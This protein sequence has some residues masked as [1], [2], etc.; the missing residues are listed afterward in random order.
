M[1]EHTLA[2]CD[3]G[4]YVSARHEIVDLTYAIKRATRDTVLLDL[5]S[6]PVDPEDGSYPPHVMRKRVLETAISVTGES[7]IE[8][9]RRLVA[10]HDHVGCLNFASAKN[11]GGGFLDGARAQEESLA[12]S[13]ALYPCLLTQPAHYARNK[14]NHSALYLD[15]AIYSPGVP[16]FRDDDGGWFDAPIECS[17]ITCAAPNAG[18]LRE[19]GRVHD[20]EVAATLQRRSR[21]VLQIARDQGIETLILGAW[22]AGA[23]GNEPTVVARTFRELLELRNFRGWFREIVF[24]VLGG[25]GNPN[26]DAFVAELGDLRVLRIR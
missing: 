26:H 12:R 5:A 9:L 1:A 18:A 24:A 25:P 4:R 3:S 2:A 21:F 8:A 22:G 11:P 19:H 10:N 16:F 15:L 20:D 13:S 7:T 23:F 6:Y 17:V 14:A